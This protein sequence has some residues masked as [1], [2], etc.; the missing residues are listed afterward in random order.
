M[1]RKTLKL[2]LSR[3]TL[4]N[5]TA[6]HLK[7]VAGGY[8]EWLTC[9]QPQYC[10]PDQQEPIGDTGPIYTGPFYSGCPSYGACTLGC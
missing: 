5:L 3:E 2:K 6:S 9:S 4:V 1:K 7:Q 10:G 8:T